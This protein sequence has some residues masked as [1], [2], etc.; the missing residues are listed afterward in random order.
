MASRTS[1]LGSAR[2]TT[3]TCRCKRHLGSQQDNS[4]PLH[5]QDHQEDHQA[6]LDQEH[7]KVL[8]HHATI[9]SEDHQPASL[10]WL[11]L[12]GKPARTLVPSQLHSDS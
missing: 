6:L 8:P 7:H 9:A 5:Q 12:C 2:C 3:A 1:T 10:T 4:A 11:L